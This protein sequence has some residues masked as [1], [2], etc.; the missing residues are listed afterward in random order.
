MHNLYNNM[1]IFLISLI[2][3]QDLD[4]QTASSC[5]MRL[6]NWQIWNPYLKRKTL[7]ILTITIQRFVFLLNEAVNLNYSITQLLIIHEFP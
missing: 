3:A 6:L 4:L 1:E 2:L 7:F 5:F